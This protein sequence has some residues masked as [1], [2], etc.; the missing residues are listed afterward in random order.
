MHL[1]RRRFGVRRLIDYLPR[2]QSRSRNS[3]TPTRSWYGFGRF[4]MCG[5]LLRQESCLKQKLAPG[6]AETLARVIHERGFPQAPFVVVRSGA[7]DSALWRAATIR[8]AGGSLYVRQPS[9]LT[10]LERSAFWQATA[11]RPMAGAQPNESTGPGIVIAVHLRYVTDPSI[12]FRSLIT[13]LPDVLQS[14]FQ[15]S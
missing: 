14:R 11:F 6:H 9:A 10:P 8:A 1:I 12:F 15:K 2:N 13:F 5:L 7:F 3:H 4:A